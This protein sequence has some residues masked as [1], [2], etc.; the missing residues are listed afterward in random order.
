MVSVVCVYIGFISD[1]AGGK[2]EEVINLNGELTLSILLDLL[3][4]KYPGFKTLY[5]DPATH[6]L[7][8][9]RQ[10]LITP[11]GK[12]TLPPSGI[13]NKIEEWSRVIFL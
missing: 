6:S 13:N 5:V 1:I 4:N 9:N 3:D 8:P 7:V 2:P 12:I 11:P 10:I